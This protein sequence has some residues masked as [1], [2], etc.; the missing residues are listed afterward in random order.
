M[1]N[2]SHIR[3]LLSFALIAMALSA[4]GGGGAGE[5]SSSSFNTTEF[6]ANYGLASIN[7]LT[8][9]DN[10]ATGNGITVAV[11]D[12]GIDLIH[13]DLTANISANSASVGSIAS[14]VQDTVG[15]GTNVAGVI[16]GSQNSTGMH[17]VAFSSTILAV[18][19]SEDGTSTSADTAAGFDY[20]IAQNAKVINYSFGAP[21]FDGTIADAV[22]RAV[23]AGIIIVAASGNDG[24]SQADQI[25][26]LANCE[27]ASNCAAFDSFDAKGLMIAVGATDS[28]NAITAFTNLAG[29]TSSAYMVAPGVSIVTTAN[30]GGTTTISGTSFS[31]PHVSGAVALILQR[32]PSLTAA[33]AV[34]LLLGS[35]TDLGATGT[36]TTF[37]VGLLNLQAAFAAQGVASIPTS[38]KVG[39]SSSPLS[40]STLS[41]GSA[42]G[43]ALSEQGFLAEAIILDAYQRAYHVELRTRIVSGTASLGTNSFLDAD[44]TEVVHAPMPRGLTFAF[45]VIDANKYLFEY[46]H[47]GFSRHAVDDLKPREKIGSLRFTGELGRGTQGH[48]AF[49]ASPLSQF[50]DTVTDIASS[51]L[52]FNTGW[53]TAPHLSMLG[54]GT[55]MSLTNDLGPATRLN[56]GFHRSTAAGVQRAGR[57]HLG[58]ARVGHAFDSGVQ[59][60]LGAGY[61]AEQGALFRTTSSGAFGQVAD[62]RSHYYSVSAAAPVNDGVTIFA[63]YTE[64]TARP[65]ISGISLFSNW[66]RIYA[67]LTSAPMEQTSGIA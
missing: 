52:F 16:A 51:G 64:A 66:S 30:G 34:T 36:D 28:S 4:C 59:L 18:K 33:Q 32:F 31:T 13:T 12:T 35:A 2:R 46:E 67:C 21:G 50:G 61:V 65:D 41:L 24:A 54:R 29:D 62:N 10:S 57:G 58:Q 63:N 37:G 60:G 15:H 22:Q 43:N 56:V 8:A 20:A 23:D 48:L 6:R 49:R 7:A 40:S 1:H 25:A 44:T 42:F 11:I 3:N 19:I 45:D 26:R 27:G 17:G 55:S 14:S 9:Y 53:T 47:V 39:G 38:S 5:T